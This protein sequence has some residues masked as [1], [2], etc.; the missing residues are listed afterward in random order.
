[1]SKLDFQNGYTLGLA[2]GGVV[3]VEDTTKIDV[4]ETLINESGVLEG[5]DGTVTEKVG[6]LIDK[7]QWEQAWYEASER[8]YTGNNLFRG[9][10]GK[11]IPPT[12]LIIANGMGYFLGESKTVE[13]IDYYLDSKAATSHQYCFRMCNNLKWLVGVN[14]SN[15]TNIGGMFLS[16]GELETIQEPLDLTN[17]TNAGLAFDNCLKLKDISFKQ[18]SISVAIKIQSSVL[19][20]KSVDSIFNGLAQVDT[21]KTL[22]LSGTLK[23]LQSQVDGANAKGWTVVGGTVVS[24]EEYYG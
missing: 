10:Q 17:V 2:S 13:Y 11:T 24:E 15:S 7:A 1:M 12:N 8:I 18:G 19:T 3:K 20:A 6:Q 21:I 4:L 14:T 5:T 23:I 16:C 22:T 9:Y